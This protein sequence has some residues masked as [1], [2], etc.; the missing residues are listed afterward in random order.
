MIS[1]AKDAPIDIFYGIPSSVPSTSE[2]LETTGGVIDC[3]AMKHLLD[4]TRAA[5]DAILNTRRARA[6]PRDMPFPASAQLQ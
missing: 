1:A 6:F 5:D 4:L 2:K 3:S